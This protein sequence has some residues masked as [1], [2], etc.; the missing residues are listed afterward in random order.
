MDS[1]KEQNQDQ[2]YNQFRE[3]LIAVNRI[4]KVVKGGRRFAFSA[5]TVVGDGE[6]GV[7]VGYAK[8]REMPK[9]ITKAMGLARK[10]MRHYDLNRGTI[11][12]QIHVHFGASSVF[13]KPAPAGTGIIAGHAVRA[14]MAA[15]GVRDIFAKVHG[16]R[17]P[18]NVVH[19]VMKGLELIESPAQVAA[20]RGKTVAQIRN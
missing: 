13:L 4:T 19:A 12:R 1:H 3:K 16:S 6:G 14:V 5:L 18:I 8:A 9:A 10:N 15:L 2:D 11:H 7:G 20:R 17:N